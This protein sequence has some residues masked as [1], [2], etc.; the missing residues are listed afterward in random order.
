MIR[1]RHPCHVTVLRSNS[2]AVLAV[3][4][5]ERNDGLYR[6]VTYVIFKMLEELSI[7]LVNSLVFSAM[8]FYPLH[9]TGD[10]ILFWLIFLTTTSIGIGAPRRNLAWVPLHTVQLN[11]PFAIQQAS[12]MLR[13]WRVVQCWHTSSLPCRPTWTWQ[14]PRCRHT[15]PACCSLWACCCAFRT[16]QT[17]GSG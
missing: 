9:L 4:C 16:S 10:F 6:P 1:L 3:G 15:S 14:M 5:R 13:C 17:T 12:S 8:V 11:T 2:G 7:T